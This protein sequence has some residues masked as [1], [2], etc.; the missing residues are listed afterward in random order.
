MEHYE[1]GDTAFLS[2]DCLQ[3]V[4]AG[5]DEGVAQGPDDKRDHSFGSLHA[6]VV[7][8]VYLDG[9]VEAINK[10][11]EGKAL[12]ALSTFAGGETQ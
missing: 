11:I 9:H 3:T 6:S 10:D 4:L 5:T 12:L 2:G 7:Q 8:F 1:I